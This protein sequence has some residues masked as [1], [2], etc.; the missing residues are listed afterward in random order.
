[1]T[2][3]VLNFIEKRKETI[4]KKRR[5]FERLM[6]QNVLGCYS[7]IDNNGTVLPV[8]LVDISHTGCLF[9]VPWNVKSDS[10]M[11]SDT[12]LTLR[13]YFT[14]KSFVPAIVT[15]KYGKEFLDKDGQTYMQYGCEFDTSISSFEA[16][17]SFIDFLYKFAEHSAIDHGESKVF[18]Y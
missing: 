9:Q 12:E 5:N 16:L 1:M 18:F 17:S 13:M 10:K 11:E 4:E 2:D 14:K 8:N 3:K 15:I 6:F 7:V